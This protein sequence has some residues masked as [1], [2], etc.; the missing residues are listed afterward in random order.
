MICISIFQESRRLALVDLY[1]AGPQ[2]DL[3]EVRLDRFEHSVDLPALMAAKPKPVILTCRRAEDGGEWQG[4][5][6]ERLALLR[7]A[8][9]AKADYVEIELDAAD[10]IRRFGPAK[11]VIAYSNL[12]ETPDDLAEIYEQALAKDPDV[13]KLV[14]PARTPEEAWALIPILAKP[15][16]PTVVMGLGPSGIMLTILARKVGAPWTYA[17]LERG[18]EAYYGQPTVADLGRVY[19]Y[20]EIE[21][22][23]KLVGVTGFEEWSR[24]TVELLNAALAGAGQPVRCLP[25][26]VGDLRLFRRVL[27][28]AKLTGA[29]LDPE[30]RSVGRSV[31]T[32]LDPA[33]EQA[34]A[35]DFLKRDGDKWHGQNIFCKAAFAALEATR[36]LRGRPVMVVGTEGLARP[37]ATAVRDA[38]GNPIV[39]AKDREAAHRLAEAVGCRFVKIE[40]VY[41]T[42]HDVLVR[43][44]DTELH[45]GYLKAGMT[46]LDLTS[47]PRPSALVREAQQRGCQ[48]V[49][50]GQLLVEQVARQAEAITGQ[51]VSRGPLLEVFNSRTQ[52]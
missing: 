9:V 5:E 19:R 31:A 17:A 10:K 43:C 25:L 20:G 27:D 45:P 41:S 39:A 14:V 29:V 18:M 8:V 21:R 11:R 36:A 52:E 26:A 48:V 7:Q 1:N 46:V 13:V 50:P 49:S 44:D 40:A 33:A 12:L 34:D 22:G 24:L 23:T 4:K 3:I 37:M 32:D 51:E 16:V 30:H 38:G 28:A 42:L 35:V 2:C 47:G 15:P 6:D